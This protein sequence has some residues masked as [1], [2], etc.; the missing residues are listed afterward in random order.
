MNQTADLRLTALVEHYHTNL[1]AFSELCGYDRPQAF[2]DIMKGKTRA[3]SANMADKIAT[4]F[5]EISRLWLQTGTGPMME[6]DRQRQLAELAAPA[7]DA[8]P[9]ETPAAPEVPSAKVIPLVDTPAI[10]GP[11][12]AYIS[13][14]CDLRGCKPFVT[15]VTVAEVAIPVSGDS[16]EPDYPNGSIVLLSKINEA[17]FIPWGHTLVLS[18]ENGMFIKR[19]M[20]DDSD[21]SFIWAESINPRYPRMHIPKSSVYDM[22]R[23]VAT[24]RIMPTM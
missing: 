8:A 5:P 13:E 14:G 9:A 18:T 7:A 6:E 24:Q 15:G 1:K 16:M 19:V 2:Y 22:Y 12:H 21:D 20:P 10:A 17:A 3:I 4:A 11:L 23:V